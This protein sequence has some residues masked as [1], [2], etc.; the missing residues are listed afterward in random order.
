MKLRHTCCAVNG[1][2]MLE[3]HGLPL[4]CAL[5]PFV[6]ACALAALELLMQE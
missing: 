2:K 6:H 4:Q 1:C 5:L 3:I